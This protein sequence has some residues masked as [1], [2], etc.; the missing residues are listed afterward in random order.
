MLRLL[1]CALLCYTPALAQF[2]GYTF[3]CSAAMVCVE[4]SM[5]N[6]VGVLL[7][8]PLV[9]TEE[10]EKF[11]AP[12][13]PCRMSDGG[14]GFCCRDPDYKDD[15]PSD[16]VDQ[17]KPPPSDKENTNE[18]KL[19]LIKINGKCGCPPPKIKLLDGS[20][21]CKPPLIET[22][23]GKCKKCEPPKIIL[24]DGS[25]GCLDGECVSNF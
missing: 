19:P 3:K 23:D 13:V 15:W 25:C 21:G 8:S 6:R 18:C 14:D 9:L 16:Y 11:R 7:K 20:C 2:E 22:P 12:L 5:C 24:P 4:K 10:Q 17:G 1:I